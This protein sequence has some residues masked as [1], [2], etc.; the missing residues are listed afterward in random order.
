M[1]V[2]KLPPV[3]LGTWENDDPVVCKRTVAMALKLGYR[4]IDTARFYGNEEAVG[5]GIEESGVARSE[6]FIGTKV[7]PF[8]EGLS[9][10]AVMNGFETSLKLLGTSYI[11]ILYVHWPVGDYDPPETLGAFNDL[12]QDGKLRHVGVSNFNIELI[13]EAQDILRVPL[14]AH[15]VERHPLLPQ[16]ELVTHAQNN[17]YILVGYSPLARGAVMNIDV[18]QEVANQHDVST[19][20]VALAWGLA[21]GGVVTIPKATSVDHLSDNFKA[22]ELQLRNNEIELIDALDKRERLIEREGAPWL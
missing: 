9:Y 16:N 13:E 19:A 1:S 5:A 12:I 17:D 21:P 6:L 14:F 15:Q 2:D 22:S 3:G 8:A 7:H 4:H 20:C 10:D 11:D 18:I